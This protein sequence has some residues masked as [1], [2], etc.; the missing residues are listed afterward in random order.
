M[1]MS[2]AIN[3]VIVVALCGLY[4]FI[5]YRLIR[6]ERALRT[7]LIILLKSALDTQAGTFSPGQGKLL[8]RA[9]VD[10]RKLVGL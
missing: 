5:V 9:I 3:A 1:S 7:L 6:V 2:A 4:F 10:A 8:T